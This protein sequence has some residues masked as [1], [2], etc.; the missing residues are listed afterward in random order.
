M[1]LKYAEANA[2]N[3]SGARNAGGL[4]PPLPK[5]GR[6]PS[7]ASPRWGINYVRREYYKHWPPHISKA[8]A[9]HSFKSIGHPHIIQPVH[10]HLLLRLH[11]F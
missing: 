6:R 7:G 4:Q 2:F 8:L 11:V 10:V 3:T 9:T 5:W 1:L